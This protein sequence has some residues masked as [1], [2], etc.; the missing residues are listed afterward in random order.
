[1]GLQ[2]APYKEALQLPFDKLKIKY[3]LDELSELNLHEEQQVVHEQVVHEPTII[4]SVEHPQD[5]IFNGQKPFRE[6]DIFLPIA[7]VARIMKNAIPANGKI[8]KEAKVLPRAK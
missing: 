7:N 6:Q 2:F 5:S 3:L 8:A 1:L 4:H